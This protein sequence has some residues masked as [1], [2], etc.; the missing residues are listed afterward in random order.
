MTGPF[1]DHVLGYYKESLEKP[2]K[3]LFLKYG[4]LKNEPVRVLKDLADFLGYGFSE[5]EV[6]CDVI[7]NIVRICSFES[8]SNFEVNKNGKTL[9]SGVENKA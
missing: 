1:W 7:S 3:I 2:E 8:L 5:E 4:E 6:N 9:V